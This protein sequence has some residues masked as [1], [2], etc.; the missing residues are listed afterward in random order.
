MKQI[1]KTL[2]IIIT[3]LS[4]IAFSGCI[5]QQ[6]KV[7]MVIKTG[8]SLNKGFGEDLAPLMIDFYELKDADRF[9]KL[10]YWAITDN[11]QQN[12]SNSLVSQAK[13]I[14]LPDEKHTY[15]ILLDDNSKVLGLVL[16]FK[17]ANKNSNWRYIRNIKQNS[18]NYIEIFIEN[19]DFKEIK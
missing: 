17:N 18:H 9:S 15:K 13:H 5:S 7:E 19:N 1:K 2:N 16:N 3:G 4:L 12:L 10:D 8:S 6:T 14:I 11:P